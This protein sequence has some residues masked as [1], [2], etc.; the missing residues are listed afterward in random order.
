MI[1]DRVETDLGQRVAQL[2]RGA[3]ERPGLAREIRPEIDHRN[4]VG[5]RHGFS[6]YPPNFNGIVARIAPLNALSNG[7][8]PTR[9]SEDG[10]RRTHAGRAVDGADLGPLS[11]RQRSLS[12]SSANRPSC[13]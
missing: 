1:D 3:V 13:P 6:R 5:V 2:G 8:S 9:R 12:L 11:K 7:K 4:R 10:R